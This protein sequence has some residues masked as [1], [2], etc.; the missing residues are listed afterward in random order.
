MYT[1]Q[2]ENLLNSFKNES[3]YIE[4]FDHRISKWFNTTDILLICSGIWMQA[5][6]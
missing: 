4:V 1:I 5:M 6:D 2:F 3:S